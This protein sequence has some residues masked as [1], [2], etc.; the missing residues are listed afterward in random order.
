MSHSPAP[1]RQTGL[2][3]AS[4][5]RTETRPALR[6]VLRTPR[7]RTAAR[8]A[9]TIVVAAALAGPSSLAFELKAATLASFDRYVRLTELR[10]AGEA[11][12]TSP[13]LWM[14]RQ[15]EKDRSR[16]LQRLERGEVPVE[17]LETRDGK[18]E[19][20]TSN[21]LIHHW[22]GTVLL[23]GVALDRAIAFVQEYDRYPARFAP[24]ISRA[25]VLSHDD[26]H[27]LVAMRTF[28]KKMMV[29]VTID[30]DYA[31]DY[32]AIGPTRTWT[33]SVATH[34]S[35]IHSAGAPDERAEPGDL[36][37]GYLWR[38]NNYCSFEQRPEGTYEQCESIS[39]TRDV[40][41]GLGLIV[42]PFI[43]SLPKDTIEFTLGQ[44]RAGLRK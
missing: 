41:F 40:P 8:L 15:T 35:Q 26:G 34:V 23:P 1:G 37:S 2:P 14:D 16:L 21:G 20:K 27:Y 5:W 11:E 28:T 39:L 19:I 4:R 12:G 43:S 22:I 6:T 3:S 18:A 25:R 32:R 33:K 7:P 42:K 29:S 9:A 10:M 24:A 13:F 36:A 17:R 31:I 30:A 44:V 38:L